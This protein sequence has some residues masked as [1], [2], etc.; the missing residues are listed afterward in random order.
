MTDRI[1][2]II[3]NSSQKYFAFRSD[4]CDTFFT[5]RD[6]YPDLNIFVILQFEKTISFWVH[7]DRNID[8]MNHVINNCDL[9]EKDSE[10]IHDSEN[11]I[12]RLHFEHK[13][14]DKIADQSL[15]LAQAFIIENKLKKEEDEEEIFD[16]SEYG[17]G[18]W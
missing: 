3:E 8:W 18:E 7:S 14:P 9:K 13:F 17:L 10:I 2:K 6:R 4:D 11:K 1:L 15:M 16:P 5:I 12:S